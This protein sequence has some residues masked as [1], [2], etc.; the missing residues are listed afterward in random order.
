VTSD[1]TS[2][3]LIQSIATPINDEMEGI[4]FVDLT[5]QSQGVLHVINGNILRPFDHETKHALYHF[6]NS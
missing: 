1:P 6:T 4:T 5:E 3:Y 2:A